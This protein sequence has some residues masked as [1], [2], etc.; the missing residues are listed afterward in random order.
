MA[1]PASLVELAAST[2]LIQP[3]AARVGV[4][5]PTGKRLLVLGRTLENLRSDLSGAAPTAGVDVVSQM[6]A[7]QATHG[8]ARWGTAEEM[9]HGGH[10]VTP[11]K[12]AG[13]ALARVP[14]APAGADQR[15]RYAGHVVTVAPTGSGKG[16]GAVIP[17]LLD[18]PGSALV[19]DV[20]GEN[21]AVT[22]RARRA[23]GHQVFVVDPFRVNKGEVHAFNLL[24]RLDPTDP[25]CVSESAILAD[26]LV[27]SD[28]KG[29]SKH[30]DE[31]AKTIL[32]GLM[33]YVVG[34]D[35]PARC[36]LG[37]VRRLLTSSEE[38]L[39]STLAEM[40]ADESA[41]FSIPARA[42][43]TIMSMPD[44]ERGSVLS[45]AKVNTAFLDDPRIAAAVSHSDFNLANIKAELMTVYLVL[46]ANKIGP[47][48]RFV[49]AFIG[50]VIAAIT[51]SS[52]QPTHRVAF[53]LDEFGQLGYMKQIEDAVSV[54]RGYGLAFWV[55]IQDLSQLKGV[56]PKW[57]TFLA[58]SAKTFYG[59]DDYDT[60]KYVSDSLGQAT[61][62]YETHNEGKNTGSGVS[63]GGGSMN[64]G[65]SAGSSQ[66]FTGRHLLTP[67][68]VMRLGP[69][70]PIVLVKGEYP[71]QL[72]RLNYLVD[73]EYVGKADPNPYHS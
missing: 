9:R 30:F 54:M 53:L 38:T 66:Q 47:N 72:T 45:T 55:F 49:R 25:E 61:I 23:M 12:H 4:D 58:N 73:A 41:A 48:A 15:F 28:E 29:G 27:I 7:A 64:K 6:A 52:T 57:Q 2:T 39:L 37:E 20:K 46:P 8:S 13:F 35:D 16:I 34:L 40:A 5:S 21:A 44:R 31:S 59:T 42:A 60:A 36:N 68:E 63:G 32:Q 51:S 70:R 14:D 56:Y 26:C 71:Y 18:Y 17:N 33:L 22:A 1:A 43:N 3:L 69:E 19:L 65:K 24:D 11:E 10:L 67:D 62:E 50:S